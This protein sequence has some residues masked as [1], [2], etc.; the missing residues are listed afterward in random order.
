MPSSSTD[1]DQLFARERWTVMRERHRQAIR[2]R[3]MLIILAMG[4]GAVGQA[5]GVLPITLAEAAILAGVNAVFNAAAAWLERSGRFAPWQFWT[6]QGMDTVIL[7]IFAALLGERGYLILPYLVF[8]VGGYALGMPL[9]ARAQLAE[10]AVGYGIGRWMGLM[11][12]AGFSPWI[13]VLEL[14]FLV[15]TGW[16]A[17]QGPIAYTRRLRRVRQ[18]LALAQDGDFTTRLPDRHLDDIGFLSVSVNAMS[19][20]VGEMVRQIQENARAV[21]ALSEVL[22]GTVD[23]VQSAARVIGDSTSAVADD[24]ARQMELLGGSERAVDALAAESAALRREATQSTEVARGLR[25][26]A[27]THAARVERAGSLLVG[28]GEDYRRLE[29][30]VD[31]LDAAGTRVS[32]FVSAIQEIAEQTNLLALNAAI[33]A[34]RAGEQGRGFAVVAGE[35]RQLAAQSAGSAT[36]VSAVVQQTAAALAEVRQRLHAGGARIGGVGE[37]AGAGRDSLGSIVAG[38]SRTVDFIE[39]ITVDVDR[40]AES[41]TALRTDVA[42]VRAIAGTSLERARRGAAAADEQRRAMEHL[43]QTTQRT[44]GTAGTLDALAARFR[45]A[46]AG[47]PREPRMVPALNDAAAVSAAGASS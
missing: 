39:R 32:G 36:E 27:E 16:L 15:G 42:R 8:A 44:A 2:M 41:M 6:V 13:I 34:A 25:V 37:V 24:A 29:L 23:E 14:V 26:E 19:Q 21:S 7:S 11:G 1:F 4:M 38:L 40:Q 35:V 9:A 46:E 43:A 28:F 31:A 30:A 3:W 47:P 33:E 10:G 45:A 20:T 5:T 18:A 17:L 12:T 22:A